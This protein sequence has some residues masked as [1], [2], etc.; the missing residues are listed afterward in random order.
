MVIPFTLRI[1]FTF[2]YLNTKLAIKTIIVL[3]A[4]PLSL[5]GA[6]WFLYLLNYNMS[7]AVFRSRSCVLSLAHTI[8]HLLSTQS[9][10][11]HTS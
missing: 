10:Q 7:V 6:F 2:I 5:V 4:V 9:G 8:I 11:G 3:L 1:I